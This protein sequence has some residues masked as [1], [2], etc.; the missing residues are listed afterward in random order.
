VKPVKEAAANKW[1]EYFL[2]E[3]IEAFKK[4]QRDKENANSDG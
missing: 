1:G 2:N 4:E 3:A